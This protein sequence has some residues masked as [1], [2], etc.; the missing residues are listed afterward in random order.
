MTVEQGVDPRDLRARG[1][2]RRRTAARLRA[3][4]R[5]SAC[6]AVIVPAAGRGASR[7]SGLLGAPRAAR[8]RPVVAAPGA[9]TAARRRSRELAGRGGAAA[10]AGRRVARRRYDCR[11]AG[12]SHELTVSVDRRLPR[13]AR[14][15]QRLRRARRRA[16]RGRRRPRRGRRWRRRSTRDRL[17]DAA[18]RPVVGPAIVA[19]PDC[20]IWVPPGWLA[21][22]ALMAH[23]CCA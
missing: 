8:P 10:S 18:P 13:R 3:S 9:T 15:A 23:S 1:V 11:Y 20:T 17:A 12:Q 22:R 6:A 16:G 19:E 14:A 2:R 5:R 7:P 21:S 4:P